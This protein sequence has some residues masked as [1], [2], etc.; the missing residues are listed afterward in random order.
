M[1]MRGSASVV[2]AAPAWWLS[3]SHRNK[4]R[5]NLWSVGQSASAPEAVNSSSFDLLVCFGSSGGVTLRL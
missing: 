1:S 3:Q 4:R 5:R 2:R